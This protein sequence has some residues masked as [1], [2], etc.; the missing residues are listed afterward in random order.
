MSLIIKKNTTFKI[1]RTGSTAPA[2][3]PSS[4]SSLH[5]YFNSS[6]SA[7]FGSISNP[8]LFVRESID[9]SGNGYN[10]TFSNYEGYP[11]FITW[12]GSSWG[13]GFDFGKGFAVYMYTK[14]TYAATSSVIPTD[15]AAWDYNPQITQFVITA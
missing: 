5:A 11:C 12:M 4:A 14:S 8:V 1:P 10:I 6:G 3:I 2:G 9:P 7:T 15:L 13:I